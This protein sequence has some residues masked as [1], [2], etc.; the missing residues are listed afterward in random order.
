MFH[1]HDSRFYAVNVRTTIEDD[2]R[3]ARRARS[4]HYSKTRLLVNDSSPRTTDYR[5]HKL[6][7]VCVPPVTRR[8]P[9]AH[10]PVPTKSYAA[11]HSSFTSHAVAD[12]SCN[13]SAEPRS[14]PVPAPLGCV[15]CP[16][17][18]DTLNYMVRC[19]NSVQ[20]PF[21]SQGEAS[22]LCHSLE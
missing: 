10:A 3:I 4:R 15:A 21:Q 11:I 12:Q 13:K 17:T 14:K 22:K 16:V 1:C 7:I 18:S 20:V 19:Q 6:G 8:T 5:G 9:G 2:L